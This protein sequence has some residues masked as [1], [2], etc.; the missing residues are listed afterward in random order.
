MIVMEKTEGR[1]RGRPRSFD[2]EAAL[3]AAMRLFWEHGYEATSLAQLTAAIGVSA[4]SLYT[5]FGDKEA[6]F[7][8]A[9]DRY[10]AR[11]G[12]QTQALM[13][14]AKSAREAVARVLAESAVRLTDPR[15]PR[16]CMV[17]LSA[18]SVSDEAARVQAELARCRASWEKEMKKR[19]E[20]GIADG[21]V[22]RDANPAALA[23]FYMA[24]LQGMSLHAK[25]GASRERLKQIGEAALLAFPANPSR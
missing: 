10:M 2:R 22:P 21:D 16:G 13:G 17:V 9:V 7:L 6:L 8:Q 5:A 20:R 18:I 14:D 15:Y 24:V 1:S 12:D 4:P 19:I 23:S 11:G 3:D 25:D